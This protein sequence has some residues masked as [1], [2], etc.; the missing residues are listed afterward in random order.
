MVDDMDWQRA[1]DELLELEKE[2]K[3]I[4]MP[5]VEDYSDAQFWQE[6]FDCWLNG[7][8]LKHQPQEC[9]CMIDSAKPQIQQAANLL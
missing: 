7:T 1:F 9:L 5:M 8:E 4:G 3:S 2:L 6:D